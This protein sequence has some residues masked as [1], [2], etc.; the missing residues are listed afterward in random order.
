[1]TNIQ[2]LYSLHKENSAAAKRGQAVVIKRNAG[3]DVH[4][5]A[6]KFHTGFSV[7]NFER[8]DV[9]EQINRLAEAYK[10]GEYVDPM[11]VT[12]ENGEILV[13]YG[14]IRLLALQKALEE[15]ADIDYIRVEECRV[16]DEAE[17]VAMLITTNDS[18]PLNPIERGLV[19][20]ELIET[21][22]KSK[23]EVAA[24]VRRSVSRINATLAYFNMPQELQQMVLDGQLSASTAWK[25]YKKQ[26]DTAADI[27]QAKLEEA[28]GEPNP[29]EVDE[30][31]ED[32]QD[33]RKQRLTPS[34]LGVSPYNNLL[35]RVSE[36]LT[37]L[38]DNLKK[39]RKLKGDRRS[40]Q[41]SEDEYNALVELV[42]EFTNS[43]KETSG[44]E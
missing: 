33:E 21:H 16:K 14:K 39:A 24:L 15:G 11:I 18:E 8:E 20:R 34:S 42:D 44:S 32:E 27:A 43:N 3:Y 22:G 1:M 9:Q 2:S 28:E 37:G 7:R 36:T 30:G 4:V 17:Q 5:S 40:L 25:L 13:R 41:L 31:I 26:G 29:S 23:R 10:N 6:L 12:V 38:S 35:T 19:Y